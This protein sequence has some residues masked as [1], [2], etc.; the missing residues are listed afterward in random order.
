MA[1]KS[2]PWVEHLVHQND[3]II[4]LTYEVRA[5]MAEIQA[6]KEQASLKLEEAYKKALRVEA[7]AKEANGYEAVE[8][9]KRLSN[10]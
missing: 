6:L 10:C 9:A 1:N 2:L 4:D 3:E 7:L 8:R 5:A